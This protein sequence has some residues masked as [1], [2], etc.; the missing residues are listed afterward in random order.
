MKLPETRLKACLGHLT[1]SFIVVGIALLVIAFLWYPSPY[2]Y[3]NGAVKLVAMLVI[4][5][6]F[7]GPISTFVVYK[8][9]KPGLMFDLTVI[10][11]VQLSALI[12]GLHILYV[13]RPVFVVFAVDRFEVVT[14]NEID[15][16]TVKYP[17]LKKR[18]LAGP[19]LA[20]AK[21]P[22]D[23][24]E[25]QKLLLEVI[26][27]RAKDI[28]RRGELLHPYMTNLPKVLKATAR[29]E[30]LVHT[31]ADRREL[32]KF[33]ARHH[34][35]TDAF[36]YFPLVGKKREVVLAID[37]ATG[38]PAGIMDIDPWSQVPAARTPANTMAPDAR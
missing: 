24:A 5:D 8:P 32:D 15:M 18:P 22:E 35:R 17:E 26:F 1:I 4:V 21:K 34:A 19:L 29:I 38:N 2:F 30:D 10:V 16:D 12:Y 7:V 20:V 25:A 3:V 27:H 28:E 36:G 6:L 23:R 11:A 9:G 13:E 33:L 37:K 31:D 14:A